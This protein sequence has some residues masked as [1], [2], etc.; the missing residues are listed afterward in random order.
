[1]KTN[2]LNHV[3]VLLSYRFYN[4]SHVHAYQKI[5]RNTEVIW[6]IINNT[7][8]SRLLIINCLKLGENIFK[9]I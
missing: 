2:T 3:F 8:I 7:N 1:M 4:M 5:M 9:S 6:I